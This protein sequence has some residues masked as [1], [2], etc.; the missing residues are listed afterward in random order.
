MTTLMQLCWQTDPKLRPTFKQILA[1]LDQIDVD[2][3]VYILSET[4]WWKGL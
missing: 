4:F 1:N 2:G 3:N